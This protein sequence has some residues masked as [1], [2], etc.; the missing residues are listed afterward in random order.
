MRQQL[1]LLHCCMCRRHGRREA[2][3]KPLQA[4]ITAI[5]GP[6]LNTH[7]QAHQAAPLHLHRL[8][9]ELEKNVSWPA[10]P[11]RGISLMAHTCKCFD[12]DNSAIWD[13]EPPG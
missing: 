6:S 1:F 9:Q 4:L 10:V 7:H 2:C 3:S 5:R 12:V 13:G 8:L 11:A